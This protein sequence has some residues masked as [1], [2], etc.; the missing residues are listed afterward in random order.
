MNQIIADY[1][2]IT[3]LML[4]IGDID[5]GERIKRLHITV[6][7]R[8]AEI[9]SK[10]CQFF[11]TD[12][13]WMQTVL[14]LSCE[15][16]ILPELRESFTEFVTKSKGFERSFVTDIVTTL[17]KEVETFKT[18]TVD[19][20]DYQLVAPMI[21]MLPFVEYFTLKSL[22]R[23][24]TVANDERNKLNSLFVGSR[25]IGIPA[26]QL[27]QLH[28]QT[29]NET[30][31][32]STKLWST[33]YSLIQSD[34]N[35]G[36][37]D[38]ITAIISNR[39]GGEFYRNF[40]SYQSKLRRN[41]QQFAMKSISLQPALCF[42]NEL[43]VAATPITYNGPVFTNCVMAL[44]FDANGAF[45]SKGLGDLGVWEISLRTMSKVFWNNLDV[46][47]PSFDFE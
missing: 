18:F 21:E 43:N 3:Q 34:Y 36:K 26:Q 28:T 33:I 17:Q 16:E 38:E 14:N 22:N 47:Q 6:S 15:H 19:E 30:Y 29:E 12:L 10:I 24:Q 40:S 42:A 35:H 45:R 5:L 9:K 2:N 23:I 25:S 13:N 31:L 46:L 41:L 8:N 11:G 4:P 7:A 37:C 1:E 20:S 27:I 32:A 44:M 39:I